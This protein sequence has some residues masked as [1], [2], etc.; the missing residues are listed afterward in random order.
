[1][2]SHILVVPSGPHDG[3][4]QEY[5]EWYD[6][7]HIRDVCAGVGFISAKRY[8]VVPSSPETPPA[9]YLAIYEIETDDPTAVLA[10]LLRRANAG[11]IG[12]SPAYDR[13]TSQMWLY[14]VRE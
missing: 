14:E 9:P 4:D 6:R 8:R 3:R 13:T 1:M 11:E 2:V 10:D 7:E 12:V 5:N